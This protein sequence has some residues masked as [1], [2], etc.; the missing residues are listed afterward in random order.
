MYSSVGC[1]T[2]KIQS[3]VERN[4]P[5]EFLNCKIQHP[6]VTWSLGSNYLDDGRKLQFPKIQTPV[7]LKIRV[8]SFV[9]GYSPHL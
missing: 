3:T 7:I 4:I 8:R 6:L 9:D 2:S 5:Q 1:F